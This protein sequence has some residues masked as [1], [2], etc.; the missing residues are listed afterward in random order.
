MTHL[1]VASVVE[2]VLVHLVVFHTGTDEPDLAGE[3]FDEETAP[4]VDGDLGV[5]GLVLDVVVS[6]PEPA[7]LHVQAR[8]GRGDV[9]AHEGTNAISVDGGRIVGGGVGGLCALGQLQLRSGKT[10]N[11]DVDVPHA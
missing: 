7:V 11:A 2:L 1:D 5:V 10:A 6:Y 3:R 4:G 9:H 8:R